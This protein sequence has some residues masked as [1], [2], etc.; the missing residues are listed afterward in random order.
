MS[1]KTMYCNN[2]GQQGH[3]FRTCSEPIISAGILLL[4]GMYEPATLPCDPKTMSVLMVRRKDSMS[5]VEFIRG[6]YDLTNMSFIEKLIS[7]MT[8]LEQKWITEETFEL[9]WNKLWGNSRESHGLEYD[10]AQ[11][12][13]NSLDKRAIVSRF[14]SKYRDPEWGFPKGRRMRGET[15]LDC[16]IREFF[17]ETNIQKEAYRVL[18]D[19]SFTEIFKGTNDVMYKHVYFVALLENSKSIN[20]KQKLTISQR[21]EVSCVDWKTITESKLITRPHYTERRKLLENLEKYI[22]SK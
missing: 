14:P 10:I 13:F 18:P 12:R 8:Q 15:D 22:S 1:L 20:L 16:A 7:N 17:E 11:E 2:C 21:R 5:Y 19:V 4:R 6:K 9:L 3:V